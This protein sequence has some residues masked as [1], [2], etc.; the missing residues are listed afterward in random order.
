MEERPEAEEGGGPAISS[1]CVARGQS[2][3]TEPLAFSHPAQDASYPA[4][5]QSSLSAFPS[6]GHGLETSYTGL[7]IPM[8]P[9]TQAIW[10]AL[11]QY[12]EPEIPTG[13]EEH[14][15]RRKDNGVRRSGAAAPNPGYGMLGTGI[16]LATTPVVSLVRDLE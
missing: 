14:A 15:I 16:S 7:E 6:A 10:M 5:E 12:T 13:T 9:N 8:S 2:T 11:I 4:P 1:P 3:V